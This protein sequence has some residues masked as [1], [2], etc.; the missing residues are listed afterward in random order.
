GIRARRAPPLRH[1][2]LPHFPAPG[3]PT[4]LL[5]SAF[6]RRAAWERRTMG[7]NHSL[8]TSESV[9]EA[10]PDKIADQIS[11]AILDAILKDDPLG[12]VAC[13]TLV[14]TGLAL[15]AGEITTKTYVDIP[16][17]VR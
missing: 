3:P 9:T 11:D 15:I 16:G 1:D 2:A 4:C 10:H 14:T 6:R 12:R 5:N 13:E 17:I 8:F 7:K